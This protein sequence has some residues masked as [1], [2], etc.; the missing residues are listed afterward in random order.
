[1]TISR[2][3]WVVALAV[4]AALAPAAVSGQEPA[5]RPAE[6]RTH[7]VRPGDTLWDLARTYLGDPFLWPEIYRVNTEIVED[8][9]WIYPGEVLTIP[10]GI[11]GAEPAVVAEA[12]E[13]QRHI[14]GQHDPRGGPP[15][16][17][18][19][20]SAARQ[21]IIMRQ[22]VVGRNAR[23]EIR[24][25]EYVSSPFVDRRGGPRERGKIV[26]KASIP[27][28]AMR[29]GR[30]RLQIGDQVYLQIP[31]S[32]V[33]LIGDRYVSFRLDEELETGGQVVVPTGIVR[34]QSATPGESAIGL[35]V[36]QY[37]D[38]R[39]DQSFYA[40]DTLAIPLDARPTA[41]E[42]G[43]EAHVVWIDANPE[44]ATVQHRVMLS[45]RDTRS[46]RP[47]DQYA[48]VR[49]RTVDDRSGAVLPEREIA[50]IQVLKVTPWALAGIIISQ[51]EPV[52]RVGSRA[53]L[54]AKMP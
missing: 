21:N 12:E 34:V 14:Q 48:V 30:E 17:V 49:D 24:T 37:D 33:P 43:A 39:I 35:V 47:G 4:G 44:L 2:S 23:P 42:R 54:I 27:G 1:M 6:A 46:A 40:F 31:G 19:A 28:T 15:P 9:H 25:G 38:M 53:K 20:T 45:T 22:G 26:A 29:V 41:I 3:S 50:V 51:T 52:V 10:G 36:E 8:P 7:T 11:A 16:T 5:A 13:A 18:F 32:T